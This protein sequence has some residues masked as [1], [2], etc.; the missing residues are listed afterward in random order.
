MKDAPL[1]LR[2]L[3]QELHSLVTE[4]LSSFVYPMGGP[5]TCPVTAKDLER[6]SCAVQRVHAI[7]EAISNDDYELV[8][9]LNAL[10]WYEAPNGISA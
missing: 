4:S 2:P 5:M 8:D 3:L 1:P 7:R 6:F 10:K 9:R